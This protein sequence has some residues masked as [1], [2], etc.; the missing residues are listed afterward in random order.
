MKRI[1]IDR[2]QDGHR[3]FIV[4]DDGVCT[5]CGFFHNCFQLRLETTG[6]DTTDVLR[7]G[8]KRKRTP[9]MARCR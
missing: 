6:G 3:L 7:S 2:H 9:L 5:L 4:R 8:H 1:K